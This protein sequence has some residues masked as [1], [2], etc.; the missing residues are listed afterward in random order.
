[1]LVPFELLRIRFEVGSELGQLSNV[2]VEVGLDLRTA[3][4]LLPDLHGDRARLRTG[5]GKYA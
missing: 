1:M 5:K 2:V 3:R 4:Q